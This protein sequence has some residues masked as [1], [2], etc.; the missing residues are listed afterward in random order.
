MKIPHLPFFWR[1]FLA[2]VLCSFIPIFV[3][4]F[5]VTGVFQQVITRHSEQ[6]KNSIMEQINNIVSEYVLTALQTATD[7]ADLP[8]IQDYCQFPLERNNPQ[9]LKQSLLI[10]D[11]FQRIR[12]IE[13]SG[14]YQVFVISADRRSLSRGIIPEQYTDAAYGS[15]GVFGALSQ[16]RTPCLFTQPHPD[17][18]NSVVAAAIAPV[19]VAGEVEPVGY[20]IVD[21]L[22][23]TVHSSITGISDFQTT[24][25]S[26]ILYDSTRCIM[27]SYFH[28]EQEASFFD[29]VF[30]QETQDT[31]AGST[32]HGTD[33]TVC[34]KLI[35]PAAFRYLHEF[36][37]MALLLALFTGAAACVIA[38]VLSKSLASPI[39]S[40]TKAMY[41][42]E[43]GNLNSC[44]PE[45]HSLISTTKEMLFLI[46][47][48]NRMVERIRLLMENTVEQERRLR[49]SEVKALQA[50]INPH[51][52][53]NTLNSIKAMAKLSGNQD[54]ADI[55]ISL[56]KLLRNEFS[57]ERDFVPLRSELDH[58]RSYFD[59]ETYRW[60][61]RFVLDEE[62]E[63]AILD[64]SVPRL[65]LQPLVENALLH[66]LE[67]KSGNG[68][69]S[70][71]GYLCPRIEGSGSGITQGKDILLSVADDGCGI[72]AERLSSL[73]H[74]LRQVSCVDGD[75]T[76]VSVPQDTRL[77]SNGIALQNTH[78][79]IIILYGIPY[80]L[81]IDSV[82]GEGTRITIRI[83][84]IPE[85][86][87]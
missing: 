4:S 14:R 84:Y 38:V 17:T 27:F 12:L 18:G 11:I 77:D 75:T 67:Q 21:I 73:Q 5:V 44:C 25:S 9:K 39:Q 83:P 59:I 52:L 60:P 33:I 10:S 74:C 79:R 37:S 81:H 66:G 2:F 55:V 48:F 64:Y 24:F 13:S 45:P 28:P 46:R 20:V 29:E 6:Q 8:V 49:I 36:Q 16:Q 3:L 32:I 70:I 87:V 47:R 85:Q 62:I 68:K 63:P 65:L 57:G 50:Q 23:S 35:I 86:P 34:G 72:P 76:I 42:A 43:N 61:G 7:M 54:I 80:G 56:G 82:H 19:M 40:L 1:L 31:V 69:L 26:L 78:R 30:L 15:W 41:Q 22:R 53:Y 58:I 71:R 51:F